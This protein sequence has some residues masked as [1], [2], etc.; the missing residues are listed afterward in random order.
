M[1]LR[2]TLICV[3]CGRRE[4]HPNN[5][6]FKGWFTIM[7]HDASLRGFTVCGE[8]CGAEWLMKLQLERERQEAADA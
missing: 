6:D 5:W 7:P 1:P 3:N 2:I 8:T 4:T